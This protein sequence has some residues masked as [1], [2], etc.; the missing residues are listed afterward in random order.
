MLNKRLNFNVPAD[1]TPQIRL[2][3]EQDGVTPNY[4][5]RKA[6]EEAVNIRKRKLSCTRGIN[7][8]ELEAFNE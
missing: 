2:L 4:W 6:L 5:L 3:A 7:L 1:L 8:S